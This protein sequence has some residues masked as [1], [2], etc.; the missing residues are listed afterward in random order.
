MPPAGGGRPVEVQSSAVARLRVAAAVFERHLGSGHREVGVAVLPLGH[1]RIPVVARLKVL[2]LGRDCGLVRGRR[3]SEVQRR[4]GG[5]TAGPPTP[6]GPPDGMCEMRPLLPRARCG[7]GGGRA[8][9][10]RAC[11]VRRLL[12]GAVAVEAGKWMDAALPFAEVVE[13]G[14]RV[15][16]ERGERAQA[17][18]H[19]LWTP[20]C[21]GLGQ[22][23]QLAATNVGAAAWLAGW[24]ARRCAKRG[25]Q[26]RRSGWTAAA[27]TRRAARSLCG[28]ER[29]PA[30]R[31]LL[32]RSAGL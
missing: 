9:G 31:L 12:G 10:G 22:G 15:V 11:L 32:P 20:V 17:R 13:E 26:R 4:C 1:V 6:P 16:S 3:E 19:H 14:V 29:A 8:C 24:L 7:A 28:V 2:H 30:A 5:G 18:H 27:E 21:R 25:W 23:Q